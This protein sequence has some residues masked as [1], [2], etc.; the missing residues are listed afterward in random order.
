MQVLH[1]ASAALDLSSKKGKKV[2]SLLCE[3]DPSKITRE[4]DVI[5]TT[6][7]AAAAAQNPDQ[8]KTGTFFT[9]LTVH[10]SLSALVHL[11]SITVL[12]FMFVFAFHIM[13]RFQTH[14]MSYALLTMLLQLH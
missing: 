14:G 9:F 12:H 4:G 8:G 7:H 2:D 1:S 13:T 6:H 11:V 3:Y 5:S 10:S